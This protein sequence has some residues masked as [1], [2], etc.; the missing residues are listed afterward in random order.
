MMFND[1]YE[2]VCQAGRQTAQSTTALGDIAAG[3]LLVVNFLVVAHNS[4]PHSPQRRNVG[5]SEEGKGDS[6]RIR[7]ASS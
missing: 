5:R 3:T 2:R 6:R 4:L 1:D 7:A